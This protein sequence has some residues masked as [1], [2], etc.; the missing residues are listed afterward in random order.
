M[1]AAVDESNTL[2]TLNS[3]LFNAGA[4]ARTYVPNQALQ[5]SVKLEGG[6]RST[7]ATM[8]VLYLLRKDGII[9]RVKL[10]MWSEYM[11]TLI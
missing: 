2:H 3:T 5:S 11:N 1:L 8:N 9:N 6:L 4:I 10:L 7:S